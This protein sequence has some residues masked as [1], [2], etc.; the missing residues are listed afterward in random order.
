MG[1]IVWLRPDAREMRDDDW[2][3]GDATPIAVYLNGDAL[4]DVAPDGTPLTDDSFLLL[5]NPS[6]EPVTFTLPPR[7]FGAWWQVVV[8]TAAE[9]GGGG[10]TLKPGTRFEA[11]ARSAIVLSRL[12]ALEARRLTSPSSR[13]PPQR[14]H[15][16]VR[17]ARAR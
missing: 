14:R 12:S 5:L 15:S 6:H 8:D 17:S 7:R 16:A 10:V 13:R 9:A 4:N 3:Q 11:I 1:D 2:R